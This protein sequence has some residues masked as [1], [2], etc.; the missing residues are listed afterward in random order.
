MVMTSAALTAALGAASTATGV[1]GSLLG[2]LMS[3]NAAKKNNAQ[4]YENALNLQLQQQ[5]WMKMMSDTAHQREVADLRAAGLN[6]LLSALSGN[7]ASTPNSSGMIAN[8]ETYGDKVQRA[9]E[10]TMTAQMNG[11]QIKELLERA[12]LQNQQQ[13]VAHTQAQ[14]N[15]AH[16]LNTEA[17]TVLKNKEA[18]WYDKEKAAFLKEIA[19]RIQVNN[20]IVEFNKSQTDLNQLNLQ[21]LPK[22]MK[23]QINEKNANAYYQTHRA[24]GFSESMS[25]G[26]GYTE[27]E[28]G[29]IGI[30]GYS[31][32]ENYSFHRNHSKSK[33][34]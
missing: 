22:W 9:F 2:G 26:D 21:Y 7:G 12:E 23:A 13:D 5:A 14:L 17:D 34:W 27:G 1:G 28:S 4:N 31:S 6:P 30:K 33:S 11:A 3:Y 24:L 25:E 19:S 16:K 10:N 29:S 20:G 8:R 32:S 15:T 18:N